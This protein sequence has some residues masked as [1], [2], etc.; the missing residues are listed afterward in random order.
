MDDIL[1]NFTVN[2]QIV[3]RNTLVATPVVQ[4]T[5]TVTQAGNQFARNLPVEGAIE[6]VMVQGAFRDEFQWDLASDDILGLRAL[7]SGQDFV[8]NNADDFIFNLVPDVFGGNIQINFFN[9]NLQGLGIGQTR[10][11]RAFGQRGA[12]LDVLLD[13]S[14][15]E[16]L[17]LGATGVWGFSETS[18]I[19]VVD[20]FLDV[21]AH[22]IPE[23][24]TLLLLGSGLTGIIGFGRKRLFR[25][26]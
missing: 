20:I 4:W 21:N 8:E 11:L 5:Q 12:H 23:P 13:R 19:T 18:P 3:Q 15:D 24:S 7:Q 22:V 25:K 26:A 17:L 16:S 2:G 6:A 1:F 14:L 9:V 10:G